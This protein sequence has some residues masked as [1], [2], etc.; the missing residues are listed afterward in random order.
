MASMR[1]RCGGSLGN[2]SGSPDIL[3]GR[4]FHQWRKHGVK[5]F[6]LSIALQSDAL[7]STASAV[8]LPARLACRKLGRRR[9]CL[10]HHCT[11]LPSK[12]V[13]TCISPGL[14]GFG[15]GQSTS[16]CTGWRRLHLPR[17][18]PGRC[19][20]GLC[21]KRS[22]LCSYWSAQASSLS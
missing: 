1:S 19:C 22:K 7:Y 3:V 18:P 2:S 14:E 10:N 11:D 15:S 12:S 20:R 21:M 5:P 16:L 8:S 13:L 9:N 17:C 4:S 6:A